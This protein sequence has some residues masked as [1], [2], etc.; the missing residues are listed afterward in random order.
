MCLIHG[1]GRISYDGGHEEARP[2]KVGR[3]GVVRFDLVVRVVE[4]LGI[5]PVVAAVDF[6]PL[7]LYQ[8]VGG[9]GET[10]SIARG[11]RTTG[12]F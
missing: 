9:C 2:N 10:F 4:E 3:S 8:P 7:G 12:Y 1:C 6:A 11:M 5:V